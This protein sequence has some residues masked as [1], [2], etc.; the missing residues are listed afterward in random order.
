MPSRAKDHTGERYGFLTAISY[1]GKDKYGKS[2][3]LC[4]CDCGVEKNYLANMLV[5]KHATS[6]GLCTKRHYAEKRKLPLRDSSMYRKY[7]KMIDRC[8]NPN[9]P[10]WGRYGG[11]GIYVCDRW[12]ESFDKFLEDMG[13]PGNGMSLD[14]IDND[15]PY[16]PENCRWATSKEQNRNRRSNTK[17]TYM[18]KTKVITEWAEELGVSVQAISYRLKSGY[19]PEDAVSKPFRNFKRK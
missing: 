6:C 9:S 16:S 10:F 19:S 13:I 7:C 15:G 8:H 14:R 11:R 18:G 12:R 1:I 2:I 4:R 3:W 17:I 5:T